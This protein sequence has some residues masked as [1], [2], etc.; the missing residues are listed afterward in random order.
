MKPYTHCARCGY[1]LA[2]L[3]ATHTCP[4]CG[5]RYDTHCVRFQPDNQKETLVVWFA[6]LGG[7]WINLHNL[8]TLA[9]LDTASAWDTFLAFAAV[10]YVVIAGIGVIYLYRRYQRGFHVSITADGIALNLPALR[11]DFFPWSEIR[12]ATIRPRP[13]NKPQIVSLELT[14]KRL[15]LGGVANVFPTPRI[16]QRFVAEVTRRAAAQQPPAAVR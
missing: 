4:E 10:A 11:R 3:P 8:P 14:E 15:D 16:A 5:T 1:D 13:E 12:G 2:G 6:I 7:G 9:R